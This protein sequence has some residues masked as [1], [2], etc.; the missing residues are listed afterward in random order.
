MTNEEKAR[1]I[2]Q[3]SELGDQYGSVD[4]VNE[5]LVANIA[6]ALDEAGKDSER[7]NALQENC[8]DL[9]C[10]DIPTGGG[11]ADVGWTVVEH[12]IMKPFDRVIAESYRDDLR[13]VIDQA[14]IKSMRSKDHEHG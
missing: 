5:L 6:K 7:L 3:A 2:I 12:H 13:E 4:V 11:D 1:A 10:H 9:R 14:I 8:W